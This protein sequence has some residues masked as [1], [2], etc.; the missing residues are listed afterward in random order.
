MI[1]FVSLVGVLIISL[2][3]GGISGIILRATRGEMEIGEMMSDKADFVGWKPE[4]VATDD[5][6]VVVQV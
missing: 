2:V 5:G 4:P 3:A 1:N 6:K